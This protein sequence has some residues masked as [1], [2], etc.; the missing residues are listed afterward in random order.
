[1]SEEVFL[2][3]FQTRF[4]QHERRQGKDAV[5]QSFEGV[6]PKPTV[7]TQYCKTMPT[8]QTWQSGTHLGSRGRSQGAK[9]LFGRSCTAVER[10]GPFLFN[11]MGR[12]N[13]G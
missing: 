12:A 4:A 9:L 7:R 6:R 5:E 2:F 13:C 1:M 10:N 3:E 8:T 11:Y